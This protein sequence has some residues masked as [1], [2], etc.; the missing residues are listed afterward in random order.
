MV[1]KGVEPV[2]GTK[3]KRIKYRKEKRKLPSL[4]IS[5]PVFC[6]SLSSKNYFFSTCENISLE[7]M[8]LS[9]KDFLKLDKL[10]EFKIEFPGKFISC[11]GKIAWFKYRSN[12]KDTKVG[13]EFTDLNSKNRKFI[14]DFI[15]EMNLHSV[16]MKV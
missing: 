16:N 3:Q 14:A 4:N 13:I 6:Y 9:G 11:K 5:L 7:G 8:C 2:N 10:M 1:N 12:S 15:L